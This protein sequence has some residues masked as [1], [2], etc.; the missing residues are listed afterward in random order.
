[1]EKIA[2]KDTRKDGLDIQDLPVKEKKEAEN[3]L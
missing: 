2:Y 3:P 1:M